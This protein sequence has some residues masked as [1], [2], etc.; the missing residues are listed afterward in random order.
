M[1]APNG[2]PDVL[3]G[4]TLVMPAQAPSIAQGYKGDLS[5]AGVTAH[6]GIDI[7]AVPGTAVIAV[8]SGVVIEVTRDPLS[9]KRI[10]IDH[11]SDGSGER[12][13]TWYFHLE[14]QRVEIGDQVEHGE[15]IGSVGSSGLLA[16]YPHLHFEV[17]RGAG[18]GRALNPHLFWL[19]G[20]GRVT[21]FRPALDVPPAEFMM[22]YPVVCKASE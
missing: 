4:Y 3:V 7:V 11:G 13:S 16:P 12:Y 1:V 14:D 17:H 8:A 2:T 9:G 15:A 6:Q 19:E 21:C 5:N 10:V 22:T 20:A 18:F